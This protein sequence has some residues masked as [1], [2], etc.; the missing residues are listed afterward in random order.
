M[1]VPAGS[2][3]PPTDQALVASCL[4]G[5]EHAW[6]QLIERYKNLIYSFPRRYGAGP[7]DSAD[8]FQSVS[9]ELF[10]ALPRLRD[11]RCV[12]GWICTVAAHES[13]RWKRGYIRRA[14]REG[15]D[16]G[17]VNAP[18]DAVSPPDGL[19]A[20]EREQAV[21]EAMASLPPRCQRMLHMLFYSDPPVP[22][23][24]VAATLGLATGSVGLT[25]ARCLKKLERALERIDATR[26][27]PA[28]RPGSGPPL[29]APGA[30]AGQPTRTV[31]I[32]DKRATL[33][34]RN[35]PGFSV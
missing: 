1:R 13:H 17:L 22:Y 10:V 20:A 25:R 16:V 30:P 29:K 27:T 12:R 19:E 11:A 18:I 15:D 24:T 33:E 4:E 9:A 34:Q 21:R 23:Q 7:A 2:T 5:N 14:E 3:A 6:R 8:V 28:A 31:R 26:A 35:E 32:G